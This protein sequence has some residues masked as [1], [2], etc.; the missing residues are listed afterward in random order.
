MKKIT[1]SCI[2]A[3]ILL[4]AFIVLSS[5]CSNVNSMPEENL[6]YDAE[7][8]DSSVDVQIEERIQ[9]DLDIFLSSPQGS[10]LLTAS[11]SEEDIDDIPGLESPDGDKSLNEIRFDGWTEEDFFNINDYLRAFRRYIDTWLQG[12]KMDVKEA[13]PT[14]LEPYRERLRGKFIAASVREFM[15]GG[16]LYGLIPIDDPSLILE[17]WIYSTVEDN[18]HIDEYLVE[19][20]DVAMDIEEMMREKGYTI[21][22]DVMRQTLLEMCVKADLW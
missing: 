12:K 22:K 20:V 16:L 19:H 17:V 18:G 13:D 15:F 2:L 7:E 9:K 6:V 1:T 3:G 10:A 5:A 8:T 14:A 11:E 4:P 21:D